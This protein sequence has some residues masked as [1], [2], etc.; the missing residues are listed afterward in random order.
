MENY[1]ENYTLCKLWT[2]K[3]HSLL[4]EKIYKENSFLDLLLQGV[5]LKNSKDIKKLI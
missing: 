2:D 3:V 4:I 5:I 1:E